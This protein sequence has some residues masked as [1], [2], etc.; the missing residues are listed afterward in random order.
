MNTQRKRAAESFAKQLEQYLA[1]LPEHQ[2]Y[3]LKG[4]GTASLESW[5]LGPKA[6]N[7]ELFRSLAIQAINEHC[8]DRRIYFK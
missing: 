2:L 4:D 1:Q 8:N 5:F 3:S 7:Q 6:E